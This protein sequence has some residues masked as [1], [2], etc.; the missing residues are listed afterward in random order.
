M[1]E[2]V[3]VAAAERMNPAARMTRAQARKWRDFIGAAMIERGEI[4][5]R[6]DPFRDVFELGFQP[7]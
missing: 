2:T 6:M 4:T 3:I 5:A 1:D 7:S